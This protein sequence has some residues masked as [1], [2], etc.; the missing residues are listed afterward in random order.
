MP[1]TSTIPLEFWQRHR[2]LPLEEAPDLLTVGIHSGTPRQL[3]EDIRLTLR[4]DVR[5]VLMSTEE[6]EQGLR[7]LMV[8]GERLGE[9][10]EGEGA[11]VDLDAS[12]NLL[13]DAPTPPWSCP[14]QCPLPEGHGDPNLGTTS[15]PTKTAPWSGCGWTEPCT[16]FTRCPA[17]AT[18]RSL[19]D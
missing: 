17:R 5:P 4:K 3:L 13:A 1:S 8:E 16:R 14:T 6:L 7:R 2:L 10:E 18:P 9:A 15:S 11:E 19:P 12:G